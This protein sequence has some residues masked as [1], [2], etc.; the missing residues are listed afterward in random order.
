MVGFL[1]SWGTFLGIYSILSI[2]LNLEVGYT[3]IANFG[4]VAFY[5]VGA[6]I[7]A[8][9][10]TYVMLWIYGVT[11]PPYTTEGI[12]ALGNI[13]PKN[14]ALDVGLFMLSLILGFVVGGLVGYLLTY[15]TLRVGPAFVGIVLL[16][17]GE[18]L[19]IFLQNFEPA[20]GSKGISGIPHP[21]IWI[22]DP[23]IR[24]GLYTVMVLAILAVIYVYAE[25]ALNSPFGR[26]L[27]AVRDDEVAALCLGKH[28]PRTKATVLFIGSGF[29]GIAG[30]LMAY[31]LSSVNPNMFVTTV[32]FNIWGMVILGGMANNKGAIV[33][34]AILT[35]V[36]RALTFVTPN[37]QITVITP[38][39]I[40]WMIVGLLIV[41][42]LMF[43]PQGLVPEKPVKTPALKAVEEEGGG[44]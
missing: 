17:F 2:S 11:A 29:A 10:T 42:V 12:I 23:R 5:A 39:Y 41:L 36:D 15:P 3:G 28:V 27:K 35:F 22:P 38:D 32:T 44:E 40:R 20:G 26:L 34:A 19:R 1:I 16:S 9:L 6:Y 7:A 30:V 4:K 8:T 37:L 31:Y 13:G 18:L 24:S 25:K 43:L 33:G 14:P 21:F